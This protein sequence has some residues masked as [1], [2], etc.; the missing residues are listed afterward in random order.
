MI[1][2]V[3]FC[4]RARIPFIVKAFG[5]RT[6]Q[7]DAEAVAYDLQN[8][9]C[10]R[11][12]AVEEAE[13]VVVLGCSV[14]RRADRDAAR[15]IRFVKRANPSARVVLTGCTATLYPDFE[16][17]LVVP[18][19]DRHTIPDHV[20]GRFPRVRDE[21]KGIYFRPVEA[22]A[23][24]TRVWIKIQEGC[25]RRCSYCIIPDLR[26]PSVSLKCNDVISHV[27]LLV[28]KGVKEIVFTGT[29]LGDWGKDFQPPGTLLDLMD[30]VN[31]IPGDFRF[32]LSSLEPW[33]LT[34]ADVETLAGW[35]KFCRFLHLPVQSGS[36]E[37]LK[38]MR[39]PYRVENFVSFMDALRNVM[40]DVRIGTDIIV[41][42]PGETE[43]HFQETVRYIKRMGPDYL[44]IFS[45]SKRPGL[46]LP[47]AP[48]VTEIRKRYSLLKSL[49]MD[50]RGR[51][52][53]RCGNRT[54]RVL[55]LGTRGVDEGNRP[56]RIDRYVPEG[57]FS[58]CRITGFENGRLTA[59][60]L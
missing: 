54:L 59:F 36:P 26:G 30:E 29:N 18:L 14:T 50:L 21:E 38:M 55:S 25:N 37:I 60:V 7:Y 12:K 48:P 15:Y 52:L 22:M 1:Q 34:R 17:D 3:N 19:K 39:R 43:R 16:A 27:E 4:Q 35:K 58:L 45:F 8:R 6:N 13:I 40:P 11:V 56:V 44:H 23:G 49:D 53:M 32:R 47:P 9:G 2:I 41:G 51:D 46:D 42:F 31:Q 57:E 24:R 28:R 33:S 20:S 5:C 10:V